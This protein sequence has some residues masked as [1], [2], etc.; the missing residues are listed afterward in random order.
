M[1]ERPTDV[2]L[3]SCY[4]MGHQPLGVA[5]PK[6]YLEREGRTV[7]TLDLAVEPFDEAKVRRAATVAISVPMH[8][9]L[10]LGARAARLVRQVDQDARIVFHGLYARLHAAVL[11]GHEVVDFEQGPVPVP[12]RA[13]LPPPA[14]YAH[15]ALGGRFIHAGY[16]EA[17]RGCLH[18]CRHCPIVPVFQGRFKAVPRDVV[19]ADIRQQVAAGAGHITFGD[20]DFLNGPTHALR[21]VRELHDEFPHVTY[22]FTA[23][24]EH[25]LRHR[26]LFE[27]FAAT[28]CVFVV[29]AVESLSDVV[30]EKLAKGHTAAD[31][32]PALAV[33]RGAGL[34]L[35]PTFVPFTPW[36]TRDDHARL[37][38]F[39][40]RHD[41]A[42]AVDPVQL[43]IR[44]LVPRGSL[45]LPDM[46][47]YI[48]GWDAERFTY[49]WEHPDPR[50]DE[51]QREMAAQAE[52]ALTEPPPERPIPARLTEPWFC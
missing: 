23:K 34:T 32:A 13:G 1:R 44:L 50:M 35:R 47:P 49:R 25:I 51:L 5:W 46:A 33:V 14:K 48:K 26:E 31:V 28:G 30:L 9:A 18:E 42:D 29:S 52:R 8:T 19:M 12:S 10:R 16:V 43:S 22:D 27:E 3:L 17:T 2:L 45:L 4:E 37:E 20:A 15:L 39:V 6:A 7:E 11:G 38:E 21:L 36:S 24:V 40:A 41:L